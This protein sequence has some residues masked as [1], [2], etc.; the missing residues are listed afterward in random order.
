[1][2]AKFPFKDPVLTH[3]GLLHP[4][5]REKISPAA[6]RCLCN[7]FLKAFSDEPCDEIV[8]EFRDFRATLSEHLPTID[9]S[10][11]TGI[12]SFGWLWGR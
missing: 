9:Y 2:L 8:S 1:M 11:N 10:D 6:V 12:E 7:R 4:R 5:Q 3:L